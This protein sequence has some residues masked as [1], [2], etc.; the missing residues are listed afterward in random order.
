MQKLVSKYALAAHLG[1]LTAAPLFL[2]PYCTE[3]WIATVLLWLSLLGAVWVIMEPS[4]IGGEMPHNA[5]ERVVRTMTSDPFSYFMLAVVVYA[6]IRW[7]NGG[8]G[9]KYD[10]EFQAWSLRSAMWPYMP[11]SV[12]G[13]AVLPFA[14]SVAMTT[15]LLGI[16]NALGKSA[17]IAYCVTV[18]MLVGYAGLYF[19]YRYLNG[20]AVF[21]RLMACENYNPAFVG[22]GFGIALLLG[23]AGMFGANENGWLKVEL[24][25][26]PGLAGCMAGLLL[27]SSLLCT[28]A[29]LAAALIMAVIGFV[30]CNKVFE[31]SGSFRCGLFFIVVFVAAGFLAVEAVPGSGLALR[32]Q[33]CEE[34][35][36]LP[37]GFM[38]SRAVLSDM[39]AKVFKENPWLGSG[40]GSFK[41]DI[42]FLATPETYKVVVPGQLMVTNGWWQLIAER[43]VIG[44]AF[45]LIGLGFLAWTYVS[46]LVAGFADLKWRPLNFLFPVLLLAVVPVMFFECS[47]WRS[48]V[49][50]V[51][52]AALALSANSAPSI[53]KPLAEK[54]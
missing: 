1:L 34:L 47:A 42:R 16:R 17:R 10:F 41:F 31:G 13:T 44:A 3:G 9:L 48:D 54:E 7:I 30:T 21:L 29:F 15:I 11:G 49:S 40:L 46:R 26:L 45:F 14:A 25:L 39:A 23:A 37:D 20:D 38:A 28:L 51:L 53:K 50:M 27:F 4:R 8:I 12:E 32:Y 24:L 43:G 5:R 19:V 33:A 18:A 35:N 2:F 6:A 22:M 36:F 52:A